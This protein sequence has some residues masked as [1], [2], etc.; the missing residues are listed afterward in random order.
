MDKNTA[1]L[2]QEMIDIKKNTRSAIENKGVSI[3]GGMKTYPTS[4]DEI[5]QEVTG[6]AYDFTRAG[7]LQSESDAVSQKEAQYVNDALNYSSLMWGSYG[8][9]ENW[10]TGYVAGFDVTGAV[11]PPGWKE[12]VIAPNII[13]YEK[14]RILVTGNWVTCGLFAFCYKLRYVPT[15]DTSRTTHM[16]NMFQACSLLSYAP[17][18]DASNVTNMND[19]FYNCRGLIYVPLYN[20]SNVTYMN[21]MFDGCNFLEAIPQFDTSNVVEMNRMFYNCT[22][23]TSIPQLDTS[24]VK[25]MEWMFYGCSDLESIPKLNANS[26]HWTTNMFEGCGN[27]TNFGGFEN[28]KISIT[29][30][31]VTGTRMTNLSKQSVLNVIDGLYDWVGNPQ[32][33]DQS[34]WDTNPTVTGV[35]RVN[36]TDEEIAVATNKGWTLR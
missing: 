29:I 23:L 25:L 14:D 2:L 13:N 10:P 12:L 7:W 28:L 27:L 11:R 15:F 16:N 31:Y 6:L 36:L 24:N 26:L 20:T 18:L 33:L 17:Y 1:E 5:R 3:V 9:F 8:N 34:K 22:S 30:D 35:L 21:G 19:M 4:I 32:G